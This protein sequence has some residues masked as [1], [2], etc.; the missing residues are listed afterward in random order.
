MKTVNLTAFEQAVILAGLNEYQIC[1]A[2]CYMG[3]KTDM[4][5]KYKVIDGKL[6]PRCKLKATIDNIEEKLGVY[7]T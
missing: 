3:Y 7:N 5:N 1:R 4:C 6:T 2:H